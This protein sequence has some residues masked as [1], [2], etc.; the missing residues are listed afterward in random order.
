MREI[1]TSGCVKSRILPVDRVRDGL[2]QALS[3]LPFGRG[4]HMPVAADLVD[5]PI[6]L[7]AVIVRIAEFDRELAAGAAATRRNRS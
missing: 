5:A 1:C 7:Q 4:A 6:N 3:T 2:L